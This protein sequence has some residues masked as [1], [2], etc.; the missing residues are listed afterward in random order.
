VEN[1]TGKFGMDVAL[2][3]YNKLKKEITYSGAHNPLIIFSNDQLNEI[4][5][6][7]ISIGTTTQCD[8]HDNVVQVKEGDMVYLY[9]DGFQDQIGGEKRKKF[10]AFHLKEL[11]QQIHTLS[12]EQQKAEL[13]KKHNEWRGKTEQTDDILIIGLKI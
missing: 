6:D 3:K 9:S 4:K 10:L 13:D 7:K 8:F 5:A 12:P 2:I 1:T 11:L